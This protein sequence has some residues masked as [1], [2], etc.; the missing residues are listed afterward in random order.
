M[1][2]K[3]RYNA[4][5]DIFV[6]N[7]SK[8]SQKFT[9]EFMCYL[10]DE[11]FTI[12]IVDQIGKLVLFEKEKFDHYVDNDQLCDLYS[13]SECSLNEYIEFLIDDMKT[14]YK[15]TNDDEYFDNNDANDE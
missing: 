6:D 15:N 12:K 9:S 13:S 4:L 1:D 3:Q 7:F 14:S 11:E 8:Q 2:M 10:N 5:Y